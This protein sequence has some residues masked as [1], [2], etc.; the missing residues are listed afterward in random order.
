MKASQVE[1]MPE[2]DWTTVSVGT[3]NHNLTAKFVNET[4]TETEGSS[5]PKAAG[6]GAA[7]GKGRVAF[8]RCKLELV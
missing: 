2:C 6:E 1:R 5:K 7:S 3:G 8:G 4:G